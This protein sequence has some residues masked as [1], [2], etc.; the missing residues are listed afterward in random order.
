MFAQLKER[1]QDK[2]RHF[3]DDDLDKKV[4][5]LV[6]RGTSE[7]LI[8]PEWSVN[9]AIVDMVNQSPNVMSEKLMRALGFVV[10]KHNA[11][12]QQLALTIL[13][14]CV[15]NCHQVIYGVLAKSEMWV[16]MAK[17]AADT[18][19]ERIDGEVRDKILCMIE[20][21]AKVL[22]QKE[23]RDTY[24]MLLEH[25][26][27]FPARSPDE[28]PPILSPPPAYSTP[29][30]VPLGSVAPLPPVAVGSAGTDPFAGMSE[31]D[32]A[33]VQAAMA[34]MDAEARAVRESAREAR[35]SGAAV[36]PGQAGAVT[37][38]GAPGRK[39][40]V[41]PP[42]AP[43]AVPPAQ[44][45][46]AAALV[47][48]ATRGVELPQ[49]AD[50]AVAA[51]STAR[52]LLEEMLSTGTD[53]RE[54]F[55]ADLAEQCVQMKSRLEEMIGQLSDE[56]QL[57]SALS[58]HEALQGTL[59]KYDESLASAEQAVGGAPPAPAPASAGNAVNS[60]VSSTM[61]SMAAAAASAVAPGSLHAPPASLGSRA[62]GP[63]FTLV[64]DGDEDGAGDLVLE[65]RRCIGGT[66]ADEAPKPAPVTAPAS[67][68]DPAPALAPD[69]SPATAPVVEPPTVPTAAPAPA[70]APL[71][72]PTPA[73]D[74]DLLGGPLAPEPSMLAP[75]PEAE[76]AAEPVPAMAATT[77]AKSTPEEA[78]EQPAAE[79][80]PAVA[81]SA[82]GDA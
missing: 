69:P 17:M 19:I 52:S 45:A 8:A 31:E 41:G 70:A 82:K 74:M 66:G 73:T 7:Q 30:M 72:A 46:A 49:D 39:A 10:V 12:V 57:A 18:S 36:A 65:S 55:V 53:P 54:A 68:T 15:K 44:A 40:G 62:A 11:K 14:T 34:E 76:P 77:D 6:Q 63:N 22:P 33:A 1:L 67:G 38:P 78:V 48:P 71:A 9:L 32:R 23:F 75:E 47:A 81:E 42:G 3:G 20:D 27:D 26:V 24:E 50:E 79:A 60:D 16:E 43:A 51:V 13:E 2:L 5:D 61:L 56:A 25:G 59:T 28:Q 64:D 80:P 21:Y 58:T 4:W 37:A 35:R 29:P